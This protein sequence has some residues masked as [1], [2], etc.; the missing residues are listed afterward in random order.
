MKNLFMRWIWKLINWIR[1]IPL[2][3]KEIFMRWSLSVHKPE[4]HFHVDKGHML[5]YVKCKYCNFQGSVDDK[6]RFIDTYPPSIYG[7][8]HKD[9]YDKDQ[10]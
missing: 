2:R 10:K 5:S 7:V 6:D 1:L 9:L 8:L 4:T 3:I